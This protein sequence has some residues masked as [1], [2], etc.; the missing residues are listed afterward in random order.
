M[1]ILI[2][3]QYFQPESFRINDLTRELK[4]RG[5]AVTVLTG[6]PNYP[7]G[8]WFAG[9]GFTSCGRERWEDIEIIRVPMMRRMSAKG[10]QLALNYLSYA[11]MA[12]LLGPVWCHGRFDIVLAYE[13]SPFT[14]GIPA[15]ILR[16]FKKAPMMFWVQDLWPESLIAT[17]AIRSQTVLRL[18]G[19]MV[20][21]I[22]QRCDQVLL[23]SEAFVEPAIAAG[24]VRERIRFFPNWAEE[25]Y[26]PL[27]SPGNVQESREMPDG[28]RV[29]FAGNLGAAQSLET[30]IRAA[31][32]L[33][34][35]ASIQWIII[36][37]GRRKKWMLEEVK[38]RGLEKVVHFLG[39]KPPEL[40][41]RYF[42]LADVLLATLRP[43]PVFSLTIPSKIQTYLACGRPIAAALDGEGARIINKSGSGIAV[44]AGDT[45]G[46]AKAVKQLHDMPSEKRDFIGKQGLLYYKQHFDREMLVDQLE[47]WMQELLR[48]KA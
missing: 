6:L 26:Q 18:V 46:L 23:Q 44:D 31:E 32:L 9:Y 16:R 45:E 33:R 21:A 14:V 40:M 8:R 41:P 1:K 2:V 7:A 3:T 25:F 43:E 13:P 24:A 38:G 22:Y 19:R 5:H 28:F 15:A 39:S 29:V 17:G 35:I 42:A 48:E 47:S 37:D 27:A 12:S 34:N 4:T 36:G 11:V 30:I 20:R 10:W